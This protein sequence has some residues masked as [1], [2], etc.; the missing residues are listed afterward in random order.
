MASH[1]PR[2]IT[3]ADPDL[4]RRMREW[5]RTIHAH[6]ETAFEEIETAALV[7][8]QL[9]ECG[10]EVHTGL[11]QT[12]VVGVLRCGSSSRAIGLRA[13]MD[14][15]HIQ[16][17]NDF[18]HR[19][20]RD[21]RMHACGHDGHTA[22]LLGAARHLA[23]KRSFDGTVYFIF[24]PAEENEGG[25]RRMVEEGLFERFAMEAVFGLHNIPGLPVGQFTILTGPA[26]A[27]FDIFEI[28]V[29]GKGGHAAMPQRTVDPVV[30][31]SQLVTALQSIVS[32]TID[33]LDAG[34][35]SVT[36]LHAGETWNVVPDTCVIRGSVRTFS[37]GV[38]NSVE[39]RMRELAAGICAAFGARSDVRYERRYPATVN[40]PAESEHAQ[41]VAARA[42]GKERIVAE[43]RPLMASEDFAY[44]LQAKAGCFALTGNGA[45]APGSP[46]ELHNPRYDFNDE[47]LGWG[48][49][50]WVRLVEETLTKP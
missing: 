38:R 18:A 16:E 17:Q 9:E 24:Q 5:R 29:H 23:A 10:L 4:A 35:V 39:T 40:A 6:P 33:P 36:S 28:T 44:M 12:G 34:V 27:S 49:T 20:R 32:R 42:F 43:G 19:S 48:A 30:V 46:C 22:M 3:D 1:S 11:A 13:D 14:A 37:E 26:L 50:Y 7:S 31:G 41:R 21:G 2:L 25:G 8:R 15:L 45:G 47:V